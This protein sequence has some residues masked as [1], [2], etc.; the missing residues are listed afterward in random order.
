MLQFTSFKSIISKDGISSNVLKSNY[1]E[2]IFEEVDIFCEYIFGFKLVKNNSK[3]NNK[4]LP[5]NIEIGSTL[6]E[7]RA[8]NYYE[9]E[10]I[11][12]K[13]K[14]GKV[15]F[16]VGIL[17]III[18]WGAYSYSDL[19]IQTVPEISI[20]MEIY[21]NYVQSM[22]AARDDLLKNLIEKIADRE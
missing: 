5:D 14:S 8:P 17:I 13:N 12:H 21:K 9:E 6:E 7:S 11:K 15:G 3:V 1:I 2:K 19:I 4:A 16:F 10:R 20:Y 18:C 22:L